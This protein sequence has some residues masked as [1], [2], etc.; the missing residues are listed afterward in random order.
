MSTAVS[1]F[2][3]CLCYAISAPRP[4]VF[5]FLDRSFP[6][7]SD[8]RTR[9]STRLITGAK[10]SVWSF[11]SQNE[12]S[13][14]AGAVL[15]KTV[16]RESDFLVQFINNADGSGCEYS[17][18]SYVVQRE[19][20]KGYILGAKIFLASDPG[21]Y[22]RLYPSGNHTGIDV[23]MY[24]AVLKSGLSMSVLIYQL[25]QLPFNQIVAVTGGSF[26]WNRVFNTSGARPADLALSSIAAPAQMAV[27]SKAADEST[28]MGAKNAAS[29]TAAFPDGAE[30]LS[31]ALD[32][33]GFSAPGAS[34]LKAKPAVESYA[35]VSDVLVPVTG[36]AFPSY[37]AQG[38]VSG[39][40]QARLF[41]AESD[42]SHPAYLLSGALPDGGEA[43]YLA[44]PSVDEGGLLVFSYIGSSGTVSWDEVQKAAPSYRIFC[45]D[46][47]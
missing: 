17:A 34:E 27:V 24:G 19:N 32:T 13:A 44:L 11:G 15:I 35:A 4:S 20:K 43:L 16:K 33:L 14:K 26:D 36:K 31:A 9:Y 46:K 3:L 6:D 40:V 1:F 37:G 38:I 7:N 2:C 5:S 23:V 42:A 12:K 45:V 28:S 25:L 10:E 22:V 8:I 41:L 18:G 21:C 29:N 39:A 30:G 47:K